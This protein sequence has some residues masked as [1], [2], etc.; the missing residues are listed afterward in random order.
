MKDRG[1]Y[2]I[3]GFYLL[4]KRDGLLIVDQWLLIHPSLGLGIQ[5]TKPYAQSHMLIAQYLG[6]GVGYF[7]MQQKS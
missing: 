6:E 2:K 4:R 7:V 5:S 3:E 1:K